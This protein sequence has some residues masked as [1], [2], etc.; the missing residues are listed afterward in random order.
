M[1]VAAPFSTAAIFCLAGLLG[2]LLLP[3]CSEI[4]APSGD[5]TSL[6]SEQVAS[7]EPAR[8]DA[9]D[10]RTGA[11]RQ[12]GMQVDVPEPSFGSQ[13]GSREQ[14]PSNVSKSPGDSGHLPGTFTPG[15]IVAG[16]PPESSAPALSSTIEGID[17]DLDAALNGFYHIPPDPIGAAGP[18]HVVAVVNT[19]IFWSTKTGTNVFVQSLSNFFSPLSPLTNT[20]DPKV[21][22]DQFAGRFVVVTLERVNSGLA[23]S[24]DNISKILVA[25]SKTS[26][27]N[28]GFWFHQI[29]SKI[30]IGGLERWADYPGFAV[31]EEAVYI[32][33]NM[34]GFPAPSSQPFGGARQWIINKTPFY[35]GG[36]ASVTVHDAATAAGGFQGTT[37]PAH[38]FGAAPAGVGTWLVLY[39]GL[40]DGVNEFLSVIRINNPITAPTFTHQLV[41]LGNIDNTAAGMPDAPQ[42]GTSVLIETN[43]SRALNAV[44]RNNNLYVAATVNPPTGPD[45]GQATAHWI[46]VNTSNLAGLTLADQGNIGGEDID[47]GA[48]TFFPAIAVNAAETVAIGFALSGP[49]VFPGA[50]YTTRAAGDAPG[51]VTATETL[52][53]GLGY[54]IRTFGGPRNRWGDYSGMAVDPSDGNTFWVFNEYAKTRGTAFGGEDGRWATRFGRFTEQLNE[55]FVEFGYAGEELGSSE[56][57]F[58]TMAEALAVIAPGGTIFIQGGGSSPETPTIDQPVNIEVVDDNP[59]SIGLP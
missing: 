30:T 16:E 22:Y 31:D 36:A 27:P 17:F 7:S 51:T 44:W 10:A 42:M 2:A 13:V 11:P 12:R 26:D 45:A 3:G 32:T 5:T 24:P 4:Q 14:R 34:F 53:A 1:R 21:I 41:P 6:S 35:S 43:D 37:Q 54:Y 49:G 56:K 19:S 20:F 55:V 15:E 58:N 23:N 29:N 28:G 40:S 50:Y 46:R 48:H 57:P 8:A 33:A 9:G 25:V 18:G 38:V 39:S 47:A 59:A 52:A